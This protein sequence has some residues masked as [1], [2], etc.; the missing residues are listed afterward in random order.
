MVKVYSQP[1]RTCYKDHEPNFTYLMFC[2]ESTNFTVF[3]YTCMC[4]QTI[5]S[6]NVLKKV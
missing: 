1:I 5:V 3:G 4:Q 6:L 2:A